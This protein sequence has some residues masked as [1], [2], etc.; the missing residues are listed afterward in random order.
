MKKCSKCGIEK[1][2]SYFSKHSS[3]KDGL[4]PNCKE[5]VKVVSAEYYINNKE[6]ITSNNKQ[7]WAENKDSLNEWQKQYYIDHKDEKSEY[8]LKNKDVLNVKRRESENN[9]LK[10]D[11]PFKLR[12]YVAC[13]I[14]AYFKD[15]K[16]NKRGSCIDKFEYS[17]D[18]LKI[19]IEKQFE[20]WMNWQNWGKYDPQSWKDDDQTTWTWQIDHIIPHST[21]QY[22]SMDDEDFKKCWALDNLRPYPAKK[23]I[24]DGITKIRHKK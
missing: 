17:F 2:E 22:S 15:N 19:H 1:D 18:D 23:N 6:A 7:Y 11:M 10:T 21:F 20:P 8:Y 4:R 14:R 3:G 16:N 13:M 9:R 24:I 5:C 12:K